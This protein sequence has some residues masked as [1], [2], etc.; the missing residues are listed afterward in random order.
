MPPKPCAVTLRVPTLTEPSSMAVL[1]LTVG[2]PPPVE[3]ST[4][5]APTLNE[6]P[7]LLKLI[8][9][10]DVWN[11]SSPPLRVR[12]APGACVILL[13][14]WTE[15]APA[16]LVLTLPSVKVAP[17]TML[18]FCPAMAERLTAPVR[19]LSPLRVMSPPVLEM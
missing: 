12:A 6:L 8:E 3:K 19:V 4:G 13:D 18:R 1:L 15:K 16:P 14:D 2:E 9:P 17:S 10:P 7:A 11:V 5:L